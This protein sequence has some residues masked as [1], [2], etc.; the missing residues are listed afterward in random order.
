MPSTAREVLG[1]KNTKA[2]LST[3]LLRAEA[4][5][6]PILNI[7][8]YK[9]S[10]YLQYPPGTRAV[11]AYVEAR[12]DGNMGHVLFFWAAHVCSRLSVAYCDRL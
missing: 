6:N 1:M 8:S 3:A 2:S 11:S 10:H 12:S 4:L 7:N 5:R 9:R